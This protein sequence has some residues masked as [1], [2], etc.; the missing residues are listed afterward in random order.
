M[1]KE[2]FNAASNAA[3]TKTGFLK[4]NPRGYF[5]ASML[6]GIYVGFGI[7][8]SYSIGGVLTGQIYARIIMGASFGV[9]LSLVIMAGAE[10]FTGNNM[11]MVMGLLGKTIKTGPALKLWLVCYAGN[12]LGAILLA[13]AF[14]GTGLATGAV[15]ELINATAVAKTSSAVFPLFLRGLLC[16]FLVC[17]AVWTGFRIKSESA[18]LIMVFWCLFAFVTTGFEHSI[19]NMTLLTISLINSGINFGAYFY[20]I[21]I[22]SIGNMAGGIL[23]V[24]LPYYLISKESSRDASPAGNDSRDAS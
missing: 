8:L 11:V 13:A 12:W 22:A 2:E 16:N 15:A 3:A 20:N 19:A 23:C 18:K 4:N 21:F 1:F 17:L 10:L 7:L 5:I 6:A 14:C 24:A 9:A